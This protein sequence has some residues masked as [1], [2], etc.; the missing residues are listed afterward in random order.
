MDSLP[1]DKVRRVR[2]VSEAICFP[3][4][5]GADARVLILGSMPGVAS[6]Q[7]QC[8][9]AHPRNAFWPIMAE[10]CGFD[11]AASYEQRMAALLQRRVALWDVIER[12]YRPGSLDSRIEPD[13]VEPNDLAGLIAQMPQLQAIAFNGG[14][15]H[16]LYLKHWAARVAERCGAQAPELLALPS[17][18][19]AHAALRPVQKLERWRAL[20]AYLDCAS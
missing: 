3:P 17:T 16:K 9:Y 7:A 18:S 15:A 13:S 10:L 6:L 8:Y 14:T 19:P 20:C 12:C 2:R 5:W 1:V 11:A 4:H